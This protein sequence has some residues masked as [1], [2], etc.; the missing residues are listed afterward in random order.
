MRS[1]LYK[2][3]RDSN[4]SLAR[5]IVVKSEDSIVAINDYFNAM[6]RTVDS[7]PKTWKYYLNLAGEYHWSDTPMEVIS[8]DTQQLIPFTKEVLVD[9]PLTRFEYRRGGSERHRILSAY[10]KQEILIDRILDPVDIDKAIA[11]DNM[12]ILFWDSTLVASNELNLIPELQRWIKRFNL[13]WNVTSMSVTDGLYPSVFL[14][15]LY[16][17]MVNEISN[18]RISNIKTPYASQ[19]HIWTYLSG[20]LGLD[21]YQEYLSIEQSLWLYRNIEYIRRNAGKEYTLDLLVENLIKTTGLSA[22]KFDMMKADDLLKD[23][24]II[25]IKTNKSDVDDVNPIVDPGSLLDPY[26]TM[27]ATKTRAL[28]NDSNKDID[29]EIFEKAALANPTTIRQVPMYEITQQLSVLS[30]FNNHLQLQSDYWIYLSA[31][32]RYTGSFTIPIPG[33]NAVNLSPKEALI[34]MVYCS[35]KA[36]GYLLTDIP[37]LFVTGVIPETYPDKSVIQGMLDEEQVKVTEVV[38]ELT[39]DLVKLKTLTSLSSL[40]QFVDSVTVQNLKHYFA[41]RHARDTHGKSMI[42]SASLALLDKRDCLLAPEGTKYV[43][44]FNFLDLDVS[45]LSNEDLLEV[46]ISCLKTVGGIDETSTGLPIQQLSMLELLD[47]LTSYG[48]IVVEGRAFNANS[49][50]EWFFS[51]YSNFDV[52]LEYYGAIDL[53]ANT[54]GS[55]DNVSVT[56]EDSYSVEINN[57]ELKNSG[58]HDEFRDIQVGTSPTSSMESSGTTFAEISKTLITNATVTVTD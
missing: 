32:G 23:Y 11:A 49:T 40:I 51:Q 7:D 52:S 36:N 45:T 20:H 43:D 30:R 16:L 24:N 15:N 14:A 29:A 5:S 28:E 56:I 37:K 22:N 58:I 48:F 26:L 4:I 2:I 55:S 47:Y 17:A 38:N 27:D 33:Q 12:D 10:P 31:I 1:E 18:I 57:K 9:H 50:I 35:N 34:L 42:E 46:V 3:Y 19:W 8:S 53:D 21:K 44:W 6:G 54:L 25:S 39:T 41:G 13:R